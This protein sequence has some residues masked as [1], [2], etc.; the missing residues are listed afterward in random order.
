MI[1]ARPLASASPFAAV[2]NT[3][4]DAPVNVLLKSDVAPS[5]RKNGV[6]GCVA[7]STT[8]G[9]AAPEMPEAEAGPSR[10]MVA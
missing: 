3:Y 7:S 2:F 6:M 1:K 4:H 5:L 9:S 8:E 10:P